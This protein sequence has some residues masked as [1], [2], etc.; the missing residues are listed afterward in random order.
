MAAR[1]APP[2]PRSSDLLDD[3]R[4]VKERAVGLVQAVR[5]RPHR[6]EPVP[7]R[8]GAAPW[9]EHVPVG[10]ARAWPA[11]A[12]EGFEQAMIVIDGDVLEHVAE[13]EAIDSGAAGVRCE[14]LD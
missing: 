9:R 14:L 12:D 4:A 3:E 7:Q 10:Q 8:L 1:P 11:R 2:T 5:E 6:H 13:I